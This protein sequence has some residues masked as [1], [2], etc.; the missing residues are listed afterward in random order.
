MSSVV[1][2]SAHPGQPKP[3]FSLFWPSA[4]SAQ[5]LVRL[6]PD[7]SSAERSEA[8]DQIRAAVADPSFQV[9]NATYVVSGAPVVVDALAAAAAASSSRRPPPGR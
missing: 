5:I 9:R 8:I 4:D 7:L 3:R 2:D 6:R 1:F